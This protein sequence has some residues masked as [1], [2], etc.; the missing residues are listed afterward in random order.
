MTG[1]CGSSC[2]LKQPQCSSL[3]T[4]GQAKADKI[5][6]FSWLALK[7]SISEALPLILRATLPVRSNTES[8]F[9]LPHSLNH[10]TLEKEKLSNPGRT[11]YSFFKK[12]FF[13]FLLKV[14]TLS[15][16]EGFGTAVP[17]WVGRMLI[18]VPS[19]LY[20]K[21]SLAPGPCRR[22]LYTLNF[23]DY[24]EEY[25]CN[26]HSMSAGSSLDTYPMARRARRVS[27]GWLDIWETHLRL[28]YSS[29]GKSQT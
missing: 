29:I 18:T 3:N 16:K 17:E 9:G 26:S 15:R 20:L 22:K 5:V 24:H 19:L 11:P 7:N 12:N 27:K 23:W 10:F 14:T 4:V 6:A 2:S 13:M 28:D 25:F 21:I 8:A 1:A